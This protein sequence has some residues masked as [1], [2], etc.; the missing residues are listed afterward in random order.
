MV[1]SVSKFCGRSLKNFR[2]EVN[3][4]GKMEKEKKGSNRIK[5]ISEKMKLNILFQQPK[6]AQCCLSS[7]TIDFGRINYRFSPSGYCKVTDL[8][9][10]VRI[11]CF[12]LSKYLL[13]VS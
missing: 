9:H 4:L 11:S 2:D 7:Y 8:F 10:I 12:S 1:D 13:S 5:Y 6:G 3:N